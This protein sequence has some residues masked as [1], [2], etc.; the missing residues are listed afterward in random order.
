MYKRQILVRTTLRF[1]KWSLKVFPMTMTSS[2]QTRQVFHVRPRSTRSIN[3]SNVSGG[4]QSPNGMTL[5]WNKPLEIAKAVFS[6]STWWRPTWQYPL[7]RSNVFISHLFL[8]TVLCCPA[9]SQEMYSDSLNMFAWV[10]L[11][12]CGNVGSLSGTVFMIS[13][14][15]YHAGAPADVVPWSCTPVSYTHL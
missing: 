12:F 6:L 2:K 13:H 7:F 14:L 5:N 9:V 3:L 10:V 15:H 4:L 1:S 11:P 8:S